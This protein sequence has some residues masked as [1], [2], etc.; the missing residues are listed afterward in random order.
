MKKFLS[1]TTLKPTGA[2]F[3][4][5]IIMKCFGSTFFETDMWDEMN[6]LKRFLTGINSDDKYA[7]G[8]GIMS[9][10]YD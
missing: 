1:R 10:G 5:P 2:H 8:R 3:L 6:R 4:S 9:M 7:L